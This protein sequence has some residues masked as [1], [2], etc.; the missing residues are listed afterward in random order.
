MRFL[1]GL[2]VPRR[3][4]PFRGDASRFDLAEAQAK[5]GN[6]LIVQVHVDASGTEKKSFPAWKAGA[7]A[8]VV[9]CALVVTPAVAYGMATGDFVYLKAVA[10][11]FNDL[12][13]AVVKATISALNKT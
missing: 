13:A 4:Y 6:G 7:T 2:F 10:G 8:F 12:A 5:S 1:P 11:Y 9:F 3:G